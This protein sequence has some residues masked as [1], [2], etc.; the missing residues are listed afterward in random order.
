MLAVSWAPVPAK[1]L[2][3][4]RRGSIWAMVWGSSCRRDVL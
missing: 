3:R 4:R 2:F 1:S